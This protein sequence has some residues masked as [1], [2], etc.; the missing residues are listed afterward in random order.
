MSQSADYILLGSISG[1]HGV[2]GWLKVFSHTAPRLKI[3]EY[4]QWFL[5][6]K[7]EDWSPVKVLDGKKQGKN[8]IALLE[9]VT[10]R[11]QVEALIGSKI[12]IHRDQLENLSNNEYYWRD[13][14]GLSVE[15]TGGMKLGEID[16]VFDTGSNDVI[17]VKDNSGAE[18]KERMLPF[19][20]DDVIISI[21]LDKS[22]M[23]VDWDPEF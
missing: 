16:W 2:K 12:A 3:T 18:V 8:I 17:I 4:S 21:N 6:Q 20:L 19:L 15:T 22:Q 11:N 10:D 5:Q 23:V 13:L 7:N 1:V 9:S 14:I